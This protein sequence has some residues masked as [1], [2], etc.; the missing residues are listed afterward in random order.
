M[1]FTFVICSAALSSHLSCGMATTTTIVL[2]SPSG[3]AI[4][5]S[6][7]GVLQQK[8]LPKLLTPFLLKGN[9]L[10]DD[11]LR[12]DLPTKLSENWFIVLPG[13]KRNVTVYD[14]F[15]VSAGAG[16]GAGAGAAITNNW[17]VIKEC[18]QE[19]YGTSFQLDDDG[20]DSVVAENC[21]YDNSGK[22]SSSRG[23]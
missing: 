20:S 3:F 12:L 17:R 11:N 19:V 2:R 6:L 23:K 15:A 1:L 9:H 16:A 7:E 8:Q 10:L 22:V 21:C 5:I 4:P 14:I 13:G 18:A